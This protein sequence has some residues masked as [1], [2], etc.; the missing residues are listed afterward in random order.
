MMHAVLRTDGGARGN[1]GPAGVGFVLE[2]VDGTPLVRGGRFLGEATNNVAEYEALLWGLDVALE[3][4]V[5]SVEVFCDSELLCK[6]ISGQYRVKHPNMKPLHARAV[7]LLSRFESFSVTHVPRS[8]NVAADA[9]AN[10]AMDEQGTVGDVEFAGEGTRQES[11]F[12]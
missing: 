7:A 3:R 2:A 4:D 8:Q 5:T 1:P 12:D 10:Q 9:L 6:Q 11:L